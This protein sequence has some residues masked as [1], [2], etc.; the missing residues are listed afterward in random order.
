LLPIVKTK[1]H[2]GY[3]HSQQQGAG[4]AALA[5]LL[6]RQKHDC[7]DLLR[8]VAFASPP[9]LD[10]KSA[11]A[12]QDFCT[13]IVNKADVIP[14]A[15]LA[16]LAVLKTQLVE[17]VRPRLVEKGILPADFKSM[18]ALLSYLTKTSD[19]EADESNW[20]M[21][22]DEAKD[23]L[24]MA[25]EKVPIQDPEHLYIP[26]QVLFMYQLWKKESSP[27]EE[28]AQKK[29]HG[30][31]RMQPTDHVLRHLEIDL[32]MVSD[33]LAPSYRETLRELVSMNQPPNP[34]PGAG[35]VNEVEKSA[36]TAEASSS[37]SFSS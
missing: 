17:S 6:L 8:V 1:P 25:L 19:N 16:N 24:R 3:I 26:G 28:N 7:G 18:R 35:D 22:A 15:S 10:Y 23:A 30:V 9:I 29:A 31:I 36:T 32:S 33:H 12:C 4:V 34:P 20:I 5:G 11:A 21:T 13:T 2:D 37:S 14:R 27:D